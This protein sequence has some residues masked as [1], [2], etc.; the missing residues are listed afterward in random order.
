LIEPPEGAFVLWLLPVFSLR[1]ET[2]NDFLDLPFPSSTRLGTA[3]HG[4]QGKRK[5]F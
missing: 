3:A 2:L 4:S 5:V 1:A